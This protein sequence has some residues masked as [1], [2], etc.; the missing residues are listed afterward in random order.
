MGARGCGTLPTVTGVG[1]GA[2]HSGWEN[3][4]W[5]RPDEPQDRL[6]SPVSG[7]GSRL[8]IRGAAGVE[9]E[10]TIVGPEG[11]MGPRRLSTR[12]RLGRALVGRRAG[13]QVKVHTEAGS[14]TFTV[15]SVE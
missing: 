13:D 1:E 9:Q 2:V 11:D 12:T 10:I 6:R 4:D 14:V 15:L 8:R 3:R 5:P 7:P